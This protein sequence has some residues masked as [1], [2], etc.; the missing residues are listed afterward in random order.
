M[1]KE[2]YLISHYGYHTCSE[3]GVKYSEREYWSYYCL[4]K[5]IKWHINC[6]KC[7]AIFHEEPKENYK[8]LSFIEEETS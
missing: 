7:G 5:I 3:C 6:K 2:A 1:S 4:D 8:Q